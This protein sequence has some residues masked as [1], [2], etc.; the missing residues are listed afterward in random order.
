M[1]NNQSLSFRF[2]HLMRG[3]IILTAF[4]ILTVLLSTGVYAQ[5]LTHSYTF[6]DLS[7]GYIESGTPV[8]NVATGVQDATL[9]LVGYGSAYNDGGVLQ[10]YGSDNNNGAYIQLP[11]D[12]IGSKTAITLETWVK[13]N[14]LLNYSRVWDLGASD[15]THRFFNALTVGTDGQSYT[16]FQERGTDPGRYKLTAGE[17]YL[18]TVTAEQVSD[19]STRLTYYINGA[20]IGSATGDIL[21]SSMVGSDNYLGKSQWADSYSYADFKEFNV[22]D[23]AMGPT[24]TSV[25]YSLGA[26]P[27]S[28]DFDPVV[29][30][31]RAA[32]IDD[33][34]ASA[35]AYWNFGNNQLVDLSG[36]GRNLGIN[37]SISSEADPSL[38]EILTSNGYYL[39]DQSGSNTY[40][41]TSDVNITSVGTHSFTLATRVKMDSFKTG[42]GSYDDLIRSGT[43]DNANAHYS[44]A[45]TD[46]GKAVFYGSVNGEYREYLFNMKDNG[47]GTASPYQFEPDKWYDLSV[48]FEKGDDNNS[49]IL[50]LYAFDP[51]TGEELS[52]TIYELAG[53]A[54]FHSPNGE[55][56]FLLFEVPW[57]D[58]GNSQGYMDYAG[59]WGYALSANQLQSLYGTPFYGGGDASGVP[60][61]STWALMILGAAGLLYVRKRNRK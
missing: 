51:V 7:D 16:Y 9:Y 1:A 11:S 58:H 46:G 42:E 56:D 38:S 10:F 28:C 23:G 13:P 18:L 4:A 17:D 27:E 50:T 5:T 12:I 40:A 33:T 25:R 21:L 6:E 53:N 45:F 59:V 61:P 32:Q 26:H 15:Q 37:G 41:Y 48:T 60:E 19:T 22:Y 34:I 35:I 24:Q 44:L 2:L 31:T 55:G 39:Q 20:C 14:A 52:T 47:T 30:L 57:N 3:S 36:N 8:T 54:E 43:R 29:T 49:S